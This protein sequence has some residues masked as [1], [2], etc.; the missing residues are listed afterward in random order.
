MGSAEGAGA[1]LERP[2]LALRSIQTGF[3]CT[4]LFCLDALL[5][6]PE[7]TEHTRLTRETRRLLRR[8]GLPGE[9]HVLLELGDTDLRILSGR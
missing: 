5:E 8:N 3:G 6:L 2:V 9:L 7:L 1:S 4:T